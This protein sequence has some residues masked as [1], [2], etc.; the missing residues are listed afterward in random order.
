MNLA[1]LW[2]S[3]EP[4]IVEAVE[5]REVWWTSWL[6]YDSCPQESDEGKGETSEGE[7]SEAPKAKKQTAP[8]MPEKKKKKAENGREPQRTPCATE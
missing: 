3:L 8:K 6:T 2:R 7:G 1:L 5:A 4:W